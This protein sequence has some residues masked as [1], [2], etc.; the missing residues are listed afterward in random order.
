MNTNN[1]QTGKYKAVIFDLDGTLADTLPL[2]IEAFRRS[3]EPAC[4]RLLTDDEINATFGHG[5]EGTIAALA[6]T[7]YDECIARYLEIYDALHDEMCPA[8][9]D[10]MRELLGSLKAGGIVVGLVT[11]K[12]SKYCDISLRRFGLSKFFDYVGCGSPHEDVKPL[13]IVE[14]LKKFELSPCEALYVG[15]TLSDIANCK[16]VG[17][18]ITSAAWAK[19]ADPVGLSEMNPDHVFFSIADLA[20]YLGTPISQ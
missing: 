17:V 5:E 15:D 1:T 6:P 9:F 11:G 14:M 20:E 12:G 4:E 10:G 2:C 19:S 18:P 7:R 16:L 3:M 13:R 8:P